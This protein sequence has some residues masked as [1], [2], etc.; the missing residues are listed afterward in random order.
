MRQM[1][2]AVVVLASASFARADGAL[3]VV[4]ETKDGTAVFA[5]ATPNDGGFVRVGRDAYAVTLAFV[6]PETGNTYIQFAAPDGTPLPGTYLV[7]TP[8]GVLSG[9]IT[10]AS[11]QLV[12]TL[13]GTAVVR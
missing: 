6:L 12:T 4:G 11:G 3:V 2:A 1:I 13:D 7:V 10:D 9:R 8:D 5:A